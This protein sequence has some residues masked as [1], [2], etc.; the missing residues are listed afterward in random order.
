MD[1]AEDRHITAADPVNCDMCGEQFST[2]LPTV[3]AQQFVRLYYVVVAKLPDRVSNLY[4]ENASFNHGEG[5]RA[6]GRSQIATLSHKLPLRHR[7]VRLQSLIS[8]S[9]NDRFGRFLVV[10]KGSFSEGSTAVLFTQTFILEKQQGSFQP[11]FFCCVD[12]FRIISAMT[13]DNAGSSRVIRH[14]GRN[15]SS[16]IAAGHSSVLD[17]IRNI[18]T[19]GSNVDAARITEMLRA[20]HLSESAE[21]SSSLSSQN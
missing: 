7:R 12:I 5:L 16:A 10:V 21:Q 11:H 3:V 19:N 6:E 1:R 2:D 18:I 20:T 13:N 15:T 8:Q 14:E 4:T 9:V 17:T